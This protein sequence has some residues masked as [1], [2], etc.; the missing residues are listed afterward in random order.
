MHRHQLDGAPD[1][2]A[3]SAP[4]CLKTLVPVYRP[5][6]HSAPLAGD[7]LVLDLVDVDGPRDDVRAVKLVLPPVRATF[8]VAARAGPM[9]FSVWNSSAEAEFRSIS[10]FV[11]LQAAGRGSGR[12]PMGSDAPGCWGVPPCLIKRQLGGLDDPDGV[13]LEANRSS[14]FVR[15]AIPSPHA[16]LPTLAPYP[17]CRP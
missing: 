6:P 11:A 4:G 7:D 10:G 17:L 5:A 14:E 2:S 1:G 8:T 15:G 3:A 13:G 12:A 9:P 16:V